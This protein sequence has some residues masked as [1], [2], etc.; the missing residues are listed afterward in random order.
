MDRNRR[1]SPFLGALGLI[2]T[3]SP[4]G[5]PSIGGAALSG[6]KHGEGHCDL[7]GQGFLT[8]SMR[9][10]EVGGCPWIPRGTAA[11]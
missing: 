1:S 4:Q 8:S 11:S 2:F 3:S 7:H 6:A 10:G 9:K 5:L